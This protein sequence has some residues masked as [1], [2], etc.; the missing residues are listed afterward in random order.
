MSNVQ[1]LPLARRRP[2]VWCVPP[3]P[4]QAAVLP[5]DIT[6]LKA[7]ILGDMN[8]DLRT[9][10]NGVLG[11]AHALGATALTAQQREMVDH[12]LRSAEG[13][14]RAIVE[15]L[16]G[17]RDRLDSATPE[18]RLR[19][20]VADDDA[21]S[22]AAVGFMLEAIDAVVVEADDGDKAVDAFAEGEFD[23]L[24]MDLEMPRMDGHA[25]VRAIRYLEREEH[26][27]HATV[28]MLTGKSGPDVEA[29]SLAAG[30]DRHLSKPITESQLISAV[31]DALGE[32]AEAFRRT[33]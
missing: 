29:A 6:K 13:L 8:H 22:R 32:A 11:L 20:L 15:L 31:R 9:P 3:E 23:L 25:A 30:A 26:R 12:L 5:R 17:A 33:A 16:G 18:R 2:A 1:S 21:I 7:D 4:D 19:I 27:G 28:F 14:E 10:L 24:I